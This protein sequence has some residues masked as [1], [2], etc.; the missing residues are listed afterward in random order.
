MAFS[1]VP[2]GTTGIMPEQIF[3]QPVSQTDPGPA[4]ASAAN[5]SAPGTAP[6]PVAMASHTAVTISWLG[7][8][9]ALVI[10]R[11]LFEFSE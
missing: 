5:N 9:I 11:L 4:P 10:L 3:G 6:A 8:V 7:I 1:Y 2:Y